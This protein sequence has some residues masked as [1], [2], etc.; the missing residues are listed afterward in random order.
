MNI[1]C[2]LLTTGSDVIVI[3]VHFRGRPPACSSLCSWMRNNVEGP[4]NAHCLPLTCRLSI[5]AQSRD[6]TTIMHNLEIGT[7]SQ[8]SE[9]VQRNLG[10]EQIPRLCGTYTM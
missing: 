1:V 10:I 7:Q 4:C 3:S 6:C 8:D 2:T 5:V 9:N